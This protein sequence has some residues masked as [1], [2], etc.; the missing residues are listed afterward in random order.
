MEHRIAYKQAVKFGGLS[1]IRAARRYQG[2]P[3]MYNPAKAKEKCPDNMFVNQLT[4]SVISIHLVI[5]GHQRA[6]SA[7]LEYIRTLEVTVE[8]QILP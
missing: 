4:G 6:L 2:K 7:P 1:I 3:R 8:S 5:C